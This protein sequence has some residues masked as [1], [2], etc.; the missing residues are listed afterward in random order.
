MANS[1][2]PLP[3]RFRRSLK[4]TAFRT[5]MRIRQPRSISSEGQKRHH[6]YLQRQRQIPLLQHR[7]HAGIAYRA[8]E[9]RFVSFPTKALAQDQLRAIHEI[10][11]PD[12]IGIE[13]AS[14]FDGDTPGAERAQ[15]RKKAKIILTNPDMLHL[16]I[17]PNHAAWS[18][19]LRHLK[20]IIVDEAHTY[21]GIFG[22]H[23]AEVMR[24]LRRI[25]R[26]YGANPQFILSSATISN[27]GE[28]AQKIAGL[29]FEIVETTARPTA[30]KASFSGTHPSSMKQ[31][32]PAAAATARPL[33]FSPNW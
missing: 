30:L 12:I 28:L 25:C 6:R 14:T 16:G 5:F 3:T 11:S 26:F 27:P 23:V 20:Y 19:V 8:D 29:P 4:N 33:S 7:R 32:V 15:I 2:S 13:D 22:S 24:R 10:F 21:R 17:L 9:P 1:T 31:K 18:R